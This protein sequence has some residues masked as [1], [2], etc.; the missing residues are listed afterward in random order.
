ANEVLVTK[1][2]LQSEVGH[3]YMLENEVGRLCDEYAWWKLTRRCWNTHV[4]VAAAKGTKGEMCCLNQPRNG[5]RSLVSCFYISFLVTNSRI[6]SHHVLCLVNRAMTITRSGMTPKAI[7]EL[8][9][10]HV[11]EALAAHEANRSPGPIAESESENGDDDR[12]GNSG[13]NGNGNSGGNENGNGEGNGNHGDN[14]GNGNRN[15]MNRGVGGF[16]P[17]TMTIGIEEAYGM[18]WKEL[19]KLMIEELSLLCPRMV[20][21]EEDKIE[22]DCLKLKNQNCGNQAANTK[23]RGRVFALGG[24]EINKDSN[25]VTDLMPIELGS[26]KV[27]VG[28]D[29]LSKYHVI[30]VYD[31]KIVQIPY[32]DEVLTIQGDGSNGARNLRLSIISCTKTQ[33]Y[34]QRGCYVFLA[35]VMEKEVKDKSEEKRLEDVPIVWDF[36]EV[37]PE[38]LHG[39][40]P[41]RQV[42][43]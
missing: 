22:S 5:T 17:V 24:G 10:Q 38:D 37:F 18:S 1:G 36:L 8:I 43:F 11:A 23:A 41:T 6:K 27:I 40:P 42:E 16:G 21:E 35:Q 3:F 7:E 13:G 39:L 30:M 26:F 4:L 20:L 28:M 33:K 9:A 2:A 34:I 12:N 31:E 25:V 32:G 29:W 19:M 14:N 15:E